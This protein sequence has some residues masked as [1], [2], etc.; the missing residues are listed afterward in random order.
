MPDCVDPILRKL[1]PGL[2][3]EP[4]TGLVHRERRQ[5]GGRENVVEQVRPPLP[6]V[7]FVEW[8][9]R[10]IPERRWI[11]P[12]WM[13]LGHVTA[14][15][16]DGGLGKSLLAQQLM[17][18]CAT[19][20]PWLG[21]SVMRCRVVGLFCEDDD[22]EL[23][24]RQETINVANGVDFRDLAEMTTIAG[25]VGQDNALMTF[26]R[27]GRGELTALWSQ[28]REA[29]LD[30]GARLVVIDTAA[31]TFGGN[32]LA[33]SEVRQFISVCLGALARDVDGAVLVCAHPSV[34]GMQS[35]T[36]AGASTAWNNTVRSRWY[37]NRPEAVDGVDPHPDSRVLTRKKANY[38]GIG[39]E[40][41]LRWQNGAFEVEGGTAGGVVEAIDARNRDRQAEEAFLACLNAVQA[42]GRRASPSKNSPNYGP[43]M[44]A[45]MDEAK[46]FNRRQL[47]SAMERL[48][49]KT[50]IRV[51]DARTSSRNTIQVIVEVER[52]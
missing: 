10:I 22:H 13:P 33:R 49:S 28:L 7:R 3:E 20:R 11:I 30:L 52:E 9:D 40:L 14:L 27:D 2:L 12:S 21:L 25:R 44:F 47:E 15:Y 48:F 45:R 18:A 17:T 46:G 4:G 38:A 1:P 51:T 23:L 29:A 26:G 41:R 19:G 16:G 5:D 35:G 43:K 8:Q 50:R 42:S 34:S 6:L 37:L 32:E 36:G 24:R 31:D 39:D